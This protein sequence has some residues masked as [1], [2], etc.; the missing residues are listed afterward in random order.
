[1]QATSIT[2]GL[3]YDD[4][5]EFCLNKASRLNMATNAARPVE[6]FNDR[7]R[8]IFNSKRSMHQVRILIT[9]LSTDTSSIYFHVEVNHNFVRPLIW[10]F[11]IRF[12]VQSQSLPWLIFGEHEL[13]GDQHA[14][15]RTMYVSWIVSVMLS[16][17]THQLNLTFHLVHE[18]EQSTPCQAKIPL[19]PYLL[20]RSPI[21]IFDIPCCHNGF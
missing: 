5:D 4:D 19:Q 12:K 3:S 21:S 11:L 10:M 6:L 7:S 20:I 13:C 2:L 9:Y 16:S 17:Y 1:M 18:A 14:M 15:P 8:S